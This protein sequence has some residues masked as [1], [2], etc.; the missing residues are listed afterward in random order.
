MQHWCG[1]RAL[2]LPL[3]DDNVADTDV[4]TGNGTGHHHAADIGG[5]G[6]APA[7]D[8]ERP[9]PHQAADGERRPEGDHDQE[10]RHDGRTG[11]STGDQVRS[12]GGTRRP[13]AGRHRLKGRSRHGGPSWRP[14]APRRSAGATGGSYQL[15]WVCSES[16]VNVAVVAAPWKALPVALGRLTRK[17]RVSLPTARTRSPAVW[18]G[19]AL[20]RIKPA[21]ESRS[22][23]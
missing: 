14:V 18:P 5:P 4:G 10:Q 23:V 7:L 13:A 3:N 16:K 21:E 11:R 1:G 15:P 17:Q 9:I 22:P 20:P 6:H 8:G 19:T 12:A 2:A